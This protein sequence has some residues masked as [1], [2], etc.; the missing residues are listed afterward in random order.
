[1]QLFS[2]NILILAKIVSKK[3]LVA[4]INLL[5]NPSLGFP[6]LEYIC[7]MQVDPSLV[8]HLAHLSRLNVAP[9]KM[10]QLVQDMQDLVSFVAQLNALDTAGT[11]PLMHM[12]A[13]F[14]VLR[15]DEVKGSI[16]NEEALSNAP[17]SMAPYFK[18][19]KVIR[20]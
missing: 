12:G 6:A 20:K 8:N 17:D 4:S 16:T 7:I 5:T 15:A 1:M 2:K 18:V 10:D 13:A 11:L 3:P 19:P 9:E 14:N